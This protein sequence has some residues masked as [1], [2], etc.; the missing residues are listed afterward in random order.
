MGIRTFKY[1]LIKYVPIITKILPSFLLEILYM[2]VHNLMASDWLKYLSTYNF[3]IFP[4]YRNHC[5]VSFDTIDMSILIRCKKKSTCSS[6]AAAP[7]SI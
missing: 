6:H 3:A 5:G 4:M 2:L 1:K 7:V